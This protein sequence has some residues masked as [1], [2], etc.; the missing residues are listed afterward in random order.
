MS[1]AG[2][3]ID[4]TPERPTCER[5]PTDVLARLRRIEEAATEILNRWQ[6]R[7]SANHLLTG[8]AALRVALKETP[9]PTASE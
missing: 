6:G 2:R 5:I 9:E 3:G 1:V 7:R 4:V 8:M